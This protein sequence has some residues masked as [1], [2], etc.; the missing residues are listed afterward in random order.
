MIISNILLYMHRGQ[1]I[2]NVVVERRDKDIF[3]E[4][5]RMI[6]YKN[7]IAYATKSSKIFQV[8]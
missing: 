7:K 8:Q 5:K 4:L 1:E 3:L 6:I 2:F